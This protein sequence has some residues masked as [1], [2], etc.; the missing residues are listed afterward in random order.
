MCAEQYCR[1]N[2]QLRFYSHNSAMELCRRY[3][4]SA[5][6]ECDSMLIVAPPVRPVSGWREALSRT[7]IVDETVPGLDCPQIVSDDRSGMIRLMK[8]LFG[9]GH[10]KIAHIG[11]ESKSYDLLRRQGVRRCITSIR[12]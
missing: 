3:Y 1:K 10:R 9:L 12:H 5:Q 2:L 6:A 7:I 11:A 4:E 8:Y